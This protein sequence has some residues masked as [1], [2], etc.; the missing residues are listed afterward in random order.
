MERIAYRDGYKYQ[1]AHSYE[2]RLTLQGFLV[3][4]TYYAL[5]PD[6]LLLIAAGYA[7][8]G[9]SGPTFDTK[10]FMRGS[11][12]HDVLYQMIGAGQLPV[13][14][15]DYAD[16]VL[17]EICREDGMSTLR[18]AWVYRAVHLFGPGG[19]SAPNPVQWAPCPPTEGE[20]G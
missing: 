17:A 4:D 16:R 13:S 20:R 15:K 6:G 19:G 14:V 2:H 8:D 9:P 10:T 1:L 18:A 7:W 11:L 3:Q 12:V 5:R